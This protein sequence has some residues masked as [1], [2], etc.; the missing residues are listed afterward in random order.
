[1]IAVQART[2]EI[3]TNKAKF[4]PHVAQAVAEAI[5]MQIQGAQGV[6]VHVL[7]ARVHGL[8]LKIESVKSELSNRMYSAILAQLAALLGAAYFFAT[9]LSH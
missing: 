6:T 7:D 8:E 9:H 2:L 3:L 4:E 5:Q 1:M